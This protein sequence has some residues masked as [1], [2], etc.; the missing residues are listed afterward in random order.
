MKKYIA[1]EVGVVVMDIQQSILA[2]SSLNAHD[3]TFGGQGDGVGNQFTDKK[4][5]AIW[6]S[7]DAW[8]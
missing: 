4:N 5:S 2:G 7:G 3:K 1:P 6:G 8:E